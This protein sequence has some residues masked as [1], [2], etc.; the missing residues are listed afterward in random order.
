VNLGNPTETTML[1]L[2]KLVA[3][4]TGVPLRTQNDPTPADDPRRRCPDIG[5]ARK[6]LGWSPNVP[7]REGLQATVE[8]FR[9]ELGRPVAA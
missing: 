9:A 4:I 5:R 7:L 2:A 8:H 3:E 1:E 6:Y